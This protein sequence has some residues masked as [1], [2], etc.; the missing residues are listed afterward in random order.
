MSLARDTEPD[1]QRRGKLAI[2]AQLSITGGELALQ[3]R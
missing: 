1:W 3:E 2:T